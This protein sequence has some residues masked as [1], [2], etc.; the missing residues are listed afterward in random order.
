MPEITRLTPIGASFWNKLEGSIDAGFT[1]THSSGIAQTTLN[2]T[3]VC[4]RP[5][6]LFRLDSSARLTQRSDDE[7]RD[8]PGRGTARGVLR[9]L[10]CS[11]AGDHNRALFR[12][13]L[14]RPEKVEVRA[15]PVVVLPAPPVP[16]EIVDRPRVRIAFVEILDR[17]LHVLPLRPAGARC[18]ELVQYLIQ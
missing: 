5:A 16:F 17:G 9:R 8:D 6:F 10:R 2:T 3:T 11:A 13:G 18:R 1:Y 15:A 14:V 12:V 7:E 4:R